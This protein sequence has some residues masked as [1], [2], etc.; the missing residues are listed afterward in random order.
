M[1]HPHETLR[2]RHHKAAVR[3]LR[4]TPDEAAFYLDPAALEA[5]H[6]YLIMPSPGRYVRVTVLE[7]VPAGRFA[8][9]RLS[10]GHEQ[11][12]RKDHF[13]RE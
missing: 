13:V 11:I 5:G 1:K 10:D 9:I 8:K 3:E 2:G 6:D 12:W 7:T 4:D